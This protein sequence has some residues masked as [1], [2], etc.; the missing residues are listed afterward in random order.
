MD[1]RARL[2]QG[3]VGLIVMFW[4][5]AGVAL[6][7]RARFCGRDEAPVEAAAAAAAQAAEQSMLAS[8][9]SVAMDATGMP[10][11]WAPQQ[12]GYSVP[13]PSSGQSEPFGALGGADKAAVG[14]GAPPGLPPLPA[15]PSSSAWQLGQSGGLGPTSL[16]M[17]LPLFGQ[18]SATFAPMTQASVDA[19][20]TKVVRESLVQV[21]SMAHS[22]S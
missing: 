7:L 22:D 5:A 16:S 6:T 13:P 1:S 17:E 20:S 11:S 15:F 8:Y 3:L 4:G 12:A 9:G 10:A 14:D 2:T 21:F 19:P 18:V